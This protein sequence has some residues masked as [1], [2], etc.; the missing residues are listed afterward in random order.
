M[1]VLV[2]NNVFSKSTYDIV[3]ITQEFHVK[4]K[5]DAKL[6]KQQP[7][8]VPLQYKHRPE[9]FLIEMQQAGI[10]REMGSVVDKGSMFTN[11]VI[12]PLKVHTAKLIIDAQYL[13]YIIDLANYPWPLEPIQ[14]LLTRLAGL[15]YT[16]DLASA[17]N[18][19][20]LSEDMGKL[21]C[22]VFG[23]KQYLFE[24]GFFGLRGLPI[25][26]SRLMRI[27]FAEMISKS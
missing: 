22:F 20:P 4:L 19:V 3:N 27:Y 5:E 26:C 8:K 9:F 21:T 11:L 1:R 2:Q 17:C 14:M 18:Q 23:G 7:S 12:V 24:R 16:S 6:R 25:F 13:N 10:I 15:C